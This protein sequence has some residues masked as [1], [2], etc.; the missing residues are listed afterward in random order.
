MYT[1]RKSHGLPIQRGRHPWEVLPER[2]PIDSVREL[3]PKDGHVHVPVHALGGVPRLSS[4]DVEVAHHARDLY[5]PREVA[6]VLEPRVCPCGEGVRL[7]P[8]SRE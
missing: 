6:R 3:Q 4:R 8:F 2:Q 1:L 5:S 7:F